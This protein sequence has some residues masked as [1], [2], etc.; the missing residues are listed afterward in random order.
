MYAARAAQASGRRFR[1]AR[2]LTAGLVAAFGAL[3]A[4]ALAGGSVTVV[5][6]LAVVAVTLPLAI[7]STRIGTVDVP[8]LAATAIVA[9]AVGHLTLMMAPAGVHQHAHAV[10]EPAMSAHALLPVPMVLTHLVVVLATTFV[11]AG[12]DRALVAAIWSALAWLLLPLLGQARVPHGVRARVRGVGLV[13][14]SQASGSTAA[15]RG[16]PRRGLHPHPSP[17][18]AH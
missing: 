12:M 13:A 2:G 11:A 15:P 1:A 6:G 9:Q 16:P 17:R 5:P 4:H 3:V 7:V 10:G 14:R 18:F 8:R